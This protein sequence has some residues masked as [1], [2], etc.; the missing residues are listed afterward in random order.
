M[1]TSQN[2]EIRISFEP[3]RSTLVFFSRMPEKSTMKA[4]LEVCIELPHPLFDLEKETPKLA[5]AYC[6][7]F[8]IYFVQTG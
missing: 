7:V 5:K 2:N 6:R 1:P 8:G 3:D 4:R